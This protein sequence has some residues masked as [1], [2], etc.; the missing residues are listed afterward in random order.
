MTWPAVL[1][2]LQPYCPQENWDGKCL[3]SPSTR[4]SFFISYS[5]NKNKKAH[6]TDKPRTFAETSNTTQQSSTE[7][8]KNKAV[9]VNEMSNNGQNQYNDS[10]KINMN[11]N[12]FWNFNCIVS[13]KKVIVKTIIINTKMKA[14]QIAYHDYTKACRDQ[15]Y[16]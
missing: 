6:D 5:P 8:H 15:I 3:C 11:Q 10:I 13:Y 1:Q 7:T 12:N 16:W 14:Y 4:K 2:V 9:F